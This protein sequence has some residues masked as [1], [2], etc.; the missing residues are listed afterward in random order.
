MQRLAGGLSMRKRAKR[1]EDLLNLEYRWPKKGDRLLRRSGDWNHGISFSKQPIS[2]HAHLWHGYMSAGAGLVEL[3]TQDGYEHERHFVIYP[4]LFNYRHGLELAMK[5]V[6]LMYSGHGRMNDHDLWKLWKRCRAICEQYEDN[7]R[8]A[9][10]VV[11]R[12]VNEFHSLD[13][14]GITFRYGWTKNGKAIK[15]PEHMVDL[16]NIRDVMEGVAGYF[17]GL[18]G[19][20]DN[21]QSKK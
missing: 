18:D 4:I 7:D 14:A 15:L 6:V 10:G 16:E 12:I 19:W 3:C 21:H 1:F 9:I 8:E 13:K 2:R 17:C 5:W 20:L 11:E